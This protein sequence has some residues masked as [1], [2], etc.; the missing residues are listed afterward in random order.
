MYLLF[1]FCLDE[2]VQA[3]L[4]QLNHEGLE[5]Q[6]GG[7]SK[8]VLLLLYCHDEMMVKHYIS[9]FKCCL[10][11]MGSFFFL[12]IFDKSPILYI[13]IFNDSITCT[14]GPLKEDNDSLH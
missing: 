14:I 10:E 4:K 11:N 7:Q 1:S 3:R 6:K 13:L 5:T 12:D 9:L 8:L 2:D